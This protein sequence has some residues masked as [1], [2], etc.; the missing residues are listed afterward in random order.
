MIGAWMDGWVQPGPDGI[1][2]STTC[3]RVQDYELEA[4]RQVLIIE[5]GVVHDH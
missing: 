3:L 2:A 4:D 5:N 1:S